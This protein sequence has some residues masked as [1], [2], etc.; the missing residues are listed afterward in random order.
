MSYVKRIQLDGFAV[1]E[2]YDIK[3]SNYAQYLLAYQA[4]RQLRKLDWNI[5]V[6]PGLEVKTDDGQEYLIYGVKLPFIIL[7][8]GWKVVQFYTHLFHGVIITAHPYRRYEEFSSYDGFEV[9]NAASNEKAN[10]R[11]K[12]EYLYRGKKETF[13]IGDDAHFSN[14]LG[15]AIMLFPNKVGVQQ[16]LKGIRHN[17]CEGVIINGRYYRTKDFSW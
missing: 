4:Y 12:E 16:I 17:M 7:K 2:H 6:V 14:E 1:T 11:C 10:R 13:M 15:R 9:Y 3:K 8:L 5:N